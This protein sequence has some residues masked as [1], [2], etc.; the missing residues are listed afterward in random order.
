MLV[1][2]TVAIFPFSGT[3][4]LE[5]EYCNRMGE[6]VIQLLDMA[7]RDGKVDARGGGVASLHRLTQERNLTAGRLFTFVY[8]LERSALDELAL[9]ETIGATSEPWPLVAQLVR[10]ASFDVLAAY[11]ERVQLEPNE[12][13][14]VDKLTTVHTRPLFDA[15]LAK[16][17]ERAGRVG[18]SVSLILFDV[19]HLSTINQEHGYGVGDRILERLGILIRQYFR[20]YDWVARHSEDSIAVLLS[21]TD[22]AHAS[23]LAERVRATVEERLEFVDHRT[24]QPVRVT[25]SVAVVNLDVAVGDV[26]DP[27]RLLADAETGVE[28]AKQA[29]RN[30]VVRL[31]GYSGKQPPAAT[32]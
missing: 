1:W 21:G 3:E 15:V 23:E 28:R 19:D 16:E 17:L 32:P 27:E 9:S 11:T 18:Q 20:Q 14:I 8:L 6:I 22:A 2:D 10:R 30:R 7:V 29:G 26:I 24:E 12:A 5:P 13:A 31:D 4:L 25:T